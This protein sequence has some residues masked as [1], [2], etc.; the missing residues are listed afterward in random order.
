MGVTLNGA[1]VHPRWWIQ[2][3]PSAARGSTRMPGVTYAPCTLFEIAQPTFCR[4]SRR[5]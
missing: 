4:P 1:T 3:P 5:R 2:R